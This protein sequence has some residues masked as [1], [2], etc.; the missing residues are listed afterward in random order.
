MTI[1]LGKLRGSQVFFPVKNLFIKFM[2]LISLSGQ[3]IQP[4]QQQ[5][6]GTKMETFSS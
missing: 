6:V 5:K 1:R 3:R 4:Q 2:M